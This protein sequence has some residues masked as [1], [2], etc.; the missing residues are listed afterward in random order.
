LIPHAGLPGGYFLLTPS[1]NRLKLAN[2]EG[3]F[4]FSMGWSEQ[5]GCDFL[6]GLQ[7]ARRLG[8]AFGPTEFGDVHEAFPIYKNCFSIFWSGA[9]W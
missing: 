3:D 6:L 2:S 5:E 9:F 7:D 1:C 8:D 4:L